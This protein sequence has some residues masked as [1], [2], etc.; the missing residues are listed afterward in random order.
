LICFDYYKDIVMIRISELK[1]QYGQGSQIPTT[2]SIGRINPHF[3]L[4]FT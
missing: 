1:Q 3:K 2:K 4:K